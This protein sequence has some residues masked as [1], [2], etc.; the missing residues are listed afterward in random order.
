MATTRR[1]KQFNSM[2]YGEVDP[3]SG[4][5]R[6]DVLMNPDDAA[7]LGIADG[8]A[9][10][11]HNRF[12]RFYGRLRTAP[13]A[14]G[15]LELFWPEGNVLFPSG[16]Y[17]PHAGIPEYN[18]EVRVEKADVFYAR[19]DRK[20]RTKEADEPDEAPAAPSAGTGAE[21]PCRAE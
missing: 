6:E 3:S 9:V 4:A 15:N 13:V 5:L 7:E 8:E 2:V 10:V 1:G 14:R 20:Y 19:K 11:V 17:E 16:V 21:P 12:G 18:T